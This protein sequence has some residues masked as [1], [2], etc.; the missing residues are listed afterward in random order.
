MLEQMGKA[1][2]EASWHLAQLSTEQ[3]NQALLVI[4]DLLEQQEA[5]ILAA[6]E[7]DMVAAR[8]SN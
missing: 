4:A 2:R 7:K 1:A 6:N 3:K 8:E 5:I